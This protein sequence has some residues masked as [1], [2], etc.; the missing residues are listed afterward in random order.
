MKPV[1][2]NSN[3]LSLCIITIILIVVSLILGFV[4]PQYYFVSALVLLAAIGLLVRQV[5]TL[6]N[7]QSQ[8]NQ[9]NDV[10]SQLGHGE[11]TNR[12]VNFPANTL[13]SYLVKNLNE[14]LDFIEVYIRET[15]SAMHAIEN[16][17]LYRKTLIAGLPGLFGK[18]LR[19]LDV[20][21]E[22][23][24]NNAELEAK[25]KLSLQLSAL[26]S[27]KSRSNLLTTQ[28]QMRDAV[29]AMQEV[30]EIT[31]D[32]VTQALTN[33]NSMAEINQDFEQVNG[34]LVSMTNLADSLDTNSNKI[35]KVSQTIAQIADQ[36]NLL[37]L[38]AA[39]EAARAGDAGRGFAVVADE[40]RNLAEVTKKA[41]SDI[42][43]SITEVLDTSKNVISNTQELTKLTSHFKTLMTDFDHS[44]KHFA[45][46]AERM[47]ERVNFARM[48]NDF[49]MVKLDHLTVVQNAYRAID[50]GADSNEGKLIADEHNCQFGQWYMQDGT[51]QYGHLPSYSKINQPR[52]DFH[53]A[54]NAMITDLKSSETDKMDTTLGTRIFESM[55]TAEQLSTQITDNIA[56]LIDE[57]LKFEGHGNTVVETEIDL[58]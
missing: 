43:S 55:A 47:Y 13:F 28:S 39:I 20:S 12:L 1:S 27:D 53:A 26:Q 56:S 57:K 52:I 15:T 6:K 49:M 18:A 9:I 29:G 36:T 14:G 8:L 30:D 5:F 44:F 3:S 48:L 40:I 50:L 21:F 25:H 24:K 7:Q 10:I 11:V 35:E 23:I 19:E 32:T 58:F 38:N 22:V 16:K 37:A 33:K 31:K 41:T 46:G 45:D 34:S 4:M 51:S 54:I 42:G 17:H 2:L